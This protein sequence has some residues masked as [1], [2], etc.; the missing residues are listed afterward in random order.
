VPAVDADRLAIRELVENWA[1]WRDA[2]DWERFATVWHP[3]EGWMTA[4]WFQG[5]ARDF[6]AASRQG[7]DAGPP[8]HSDRIAVVGAGIGG[9]AAA[10]PAG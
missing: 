2:G 7:F 10:A 4:T 6:I 5:P 8:R 1:L 3:T 9:L